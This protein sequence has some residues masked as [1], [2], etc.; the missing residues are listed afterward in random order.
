MLQFSSSLGLMR[1]LRRSVYL[2]VVKGS[3]YLD[4]TETRV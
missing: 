1:V 4:I 3:C 2:S